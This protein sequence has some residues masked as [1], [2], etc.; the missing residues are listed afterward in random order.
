MTTHNELVI[1]GVRTSSFPFQIIIK[2][3]P[4]FELSESKTQLWEHSGISGAIIQSNKHR[5]PIKKKYTFQMVEPKEGDLN[6]FMALLTRERF[7][8]ESESVKTTK[9]WCYKIEATQ[10]IQETATLSVCEVTFIC[11]PTKFFKEVDRQE[12]TVSGVLQVK[13]SALAFPKITVVGQSASETSF[14]VGDQVIRLE[15]LSESLVMTN[16]PDNPSFVTAGGQLVKW[17]GDFIT[18]DSS[19]GEPVGVVLGPG[20]QSLTFETV[21]GWA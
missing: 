6:R 8:L 3:A 20:I 17:A 1:D 19:R 9:W 5:L 10:V 14:T 2:E 11:H 13:G 4:S 12:L 15:K 18:V 7:W 21:W 16:H